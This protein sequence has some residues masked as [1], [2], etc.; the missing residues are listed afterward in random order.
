MTTTL[1]ISWVDS[2]IFELLVWWPTLKNAF[3]HNF[4]VVHSQISLGFHDQWIIFDYESLVRVDAPKYFNKFEYPYS[5]Y[6]VSFMEHMLESS[7]GGHI[8]NKCKV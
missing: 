1:I 2:T 8:M 5:S 3:A 7:F 6:Q 4:Q